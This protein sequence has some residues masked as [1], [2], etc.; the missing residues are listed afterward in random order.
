MKR[1]T[2]RTWIIV[3]GL[4]AVITAVQPAR[5]GWTADLLGN[6][7]SGTMVTGI[8]LL[9]VAGFLMMLPGAWLPS[10]V[11]GGVGLLLLLSGGAA[12][13]GTITTWLK[14]WWWALGLG[15][16]ALLYV[17]RPKQVTHIIHVGGPPR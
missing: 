15:L 17:K 16:V 13:S 12:F 7:I 14:Q 8:L 4:L 1:K 5:Q 3:L 9:I 6:F 11:T 2:V 10:L